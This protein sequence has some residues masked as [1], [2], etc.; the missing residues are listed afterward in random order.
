MS[1]GQSRALKPSGPGKTLLCLSPLGLPFVVLFLGGL[2]MALVQ[3]LG[4]WLPVD[5]QGDMLDGFRAALEPNLLA[6]LGLSLGIALIAA[7][8]SVAVGALV[9]YQLWKLP[10]RLRQLAVVYKVGLILPHIA[11]AFIV[12]ILWT[13]SG[14]FA[15]VG[16]WL[17]LVETPADFPAVLFSGNGLGMILAYAYKETPFVILL[18]MAVLARTDPRLVT[19]GRMLGASEVTV[20]WRIVV[21]RIM[22][23]VNTAFIILYLYTFGAFDIPFLLGESSPGMLS[24]EIY[25]LYFKRDLVNRPTAMAMLMLMFA[26]SVV[27]IM[28]YSRVALRLEQGSASYERLDVV[29]AHRAVFAVSLAGVGWICSRSRLAF[30]GR[31]SGGD[32]SCGIR[33]S[34]QPRGPDSHSPGFLRGLFIGHGGGDSHALLSSGA[35]FGAA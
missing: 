27:L 17:G 33:L 5:Y 26:F 16:H 15:S 8:V 30:P 29:G 24:I 21:P 20:F 11:V 31:R 19:T 7:G 23:A 22:P 25:N 12:L 2:T 9:A 14:F 28:L 6:S 18:V 32:Q 4:F 3:A 34:V 35:S 13:Q 1:S 10:S